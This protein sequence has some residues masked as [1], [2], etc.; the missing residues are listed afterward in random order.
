M[1]VTSRSSSSELSSPALMIVY[2]E[3]RITS[4]ESRN[5]A[6]LVQID[7]GLLADDVGVSPTDALDLSQGVH[8]L[9]LSI[10][11]GVQQTENVLVIVRLVGLLRHESV[12][13]LPGIVGEPLGRRGTWWR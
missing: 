2:F 11:V 9:A 1:M 4:R 12:A 10:D 8:D 7:V 5:D 6:P 13:L 3:P